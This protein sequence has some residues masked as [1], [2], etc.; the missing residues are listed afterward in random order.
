MPG[1]VDGNGGMSI[2]DATMLIDYLAGTEGIDILL[3]AADVD[4]NETVNI[5]D[6]AAIID[7]LV[8]Q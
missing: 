7:M 1:D 6:V 4:G 2:A 8:S 3:E 5:G